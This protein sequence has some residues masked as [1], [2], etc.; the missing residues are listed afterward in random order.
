MRIVKEKGRKGSNKNQKEAKEKNDRNKYGKKD[1]HAHFIH[2]YI[3]VCV[4]QTRRQCGL[5]LRSWRLTW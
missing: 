3:S 5:S 1:M 4:L 2:V